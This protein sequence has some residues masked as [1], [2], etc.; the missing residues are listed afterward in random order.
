MVLGAGKDVCYQPQFDSETYM[1]QGEEGVFKPSFD[2]HTLTLISHAGSC[3][4]LRTN[5]YL[6][7]YF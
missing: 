2:L 5:K 7:F 6:V 4:C 1:V 3:M